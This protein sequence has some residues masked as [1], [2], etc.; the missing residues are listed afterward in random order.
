MG[1]YGRKLV[2]RLKKDF[3]YSIPKDLKIKKCNPGPHQRACGDFSW[4]FHSW[5][6]PSWLRLGSQF[7]V[8]KCAMAETLGIADLGRGV[9]IL[10]EK[11][12]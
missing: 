9:F 2:K 10:P 8:R 6:D 1:F 11:P 3:D 7:S 12:A 5:S 4:R